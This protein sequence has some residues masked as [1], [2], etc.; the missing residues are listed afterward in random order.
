MWH[1]V[2]A[3]LGDKGIICVED[4]VHEIFTVGPAF[5]EANNFLWPFKLSS[6]KVSTRPGSH[7][8]AHTLLCVPPR[9]TNYLPSP[10]VL[11]LHCPSLRFVEGAR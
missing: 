7:T 2:Q 6:A 10:L 4:L 9:N 11:R 5:K 8:N 3:A 1:A